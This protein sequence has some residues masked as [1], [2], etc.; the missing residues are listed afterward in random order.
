MHSLLHG[1]QHFLGQ[2]A[3]GLLLAFLDQRLGRDRHGGATLHF[4]LA[5]LPLA[6]L[7]DVVRVEIVC[8][9][10]VSGLD[11]SDLVGAVGV[12][13]QPDSRLDRQNVPLLRGWVNVRLEMHSDQILV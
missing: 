6:L 4:W 11:L 8:R 10:K 13:P 9:H 2:I 3:D 12:E 5:A 7:H 1:R